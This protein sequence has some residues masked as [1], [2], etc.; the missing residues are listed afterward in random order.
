MTLDRN[1]LEMACGHVDEALVEEAKAAYRRIPVSIN[2]EHG[3][4]GFNPQTGT[5]F[6]SK[7]SDPSPKP[8]DVDEADFVVGYVAARRNITIDQFDYEPVKRG[9]RSDI[10]DFRIR[11]DPFPDILNLRDPTTV[12]KRPDIPLLLINDKPLDK[13]YIDYKISEEKPKWDKVVLEPDIKPI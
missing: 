2:T 1:Y 5:E 6:F 9:D 11:P 12:P 10:I 4:F 13:P 8:R 7:L 3:D